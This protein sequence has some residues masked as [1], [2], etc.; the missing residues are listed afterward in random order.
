MLFMYNFI[1]TIFNIRRTSYDELKL[2]LSN[3]ATFVM[4]CTSNKCDTLLN[5]TNIDMQNIFFQIYWNNILHFN[6]WFDLAQNIIGMGGCEHYLLRSCM[7]CR[8]CLYNF[9]LTTFFIW[10]TVYI[11]F[12]FNIVKVGETCFMLY[13]KQVYHT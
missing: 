13:V 2:P 3:N 11:K 5:D 6:N 4:R 9:M 1:H 12:Y 8:L 7:S 10:C